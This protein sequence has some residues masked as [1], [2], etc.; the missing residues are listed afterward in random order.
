MELLK[1]INAGAK[2]LQDESLTAEQAAANDYGKSVKEK[3]AVITTTEKEIVHN[4]EDLAGLEESPNSH[5]LSRPGTQAPSSPPFLRTQEWMKP[6]FASHVA[7]WQ[8][9]QSS[10]GH[11]V[12]MSK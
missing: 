11:F 12:M 3:Y 10:S 2:E 7:V 8:R 4:R 6:K 9:R 1:K 5:T